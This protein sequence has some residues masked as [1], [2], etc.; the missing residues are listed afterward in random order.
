MRNIEKISCKT[1]GDVKQLNFKKWQPYWIF[2]ISSFLIIALKL[3]LTSTS[4]TSMY[5]LCYLKIISE[6]LVPFQ[7]VSMRCN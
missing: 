7:V 2:D 5:N 4:K 1:R 3:G 6:S